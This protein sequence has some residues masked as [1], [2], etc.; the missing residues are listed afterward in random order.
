MATEDEDKGICHLQILF[1]VLI[2]IAWKSRI[3]LTFYIL[4]L[5]TYIADSPP[6]FFFKVHLCAEYIDTW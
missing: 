3:I 6:P 2:L 5:K 1:S 4:S